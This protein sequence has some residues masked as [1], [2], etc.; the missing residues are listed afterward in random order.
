M[1]NIQQTFFISNRVS[2][3]I[4][5]YNYAEYVL[6]A[7]KSALDQK[8]KDLEVIVVDDG[9]T[10]NTEKILRPYKDRIKYLFQEN[11]GLSAAR[12]TGIK[13][14]T[15]EFIL[16]LDADDIIGPGVI[17]SHLNYLKRNPDIYITVCE[18]RVFDHTTAEGYPVPISD[19][20]KLFHENLGVHLCYFN[21]AP[22]HAFFSKRKAIIQT[23]WFDSQ[24]KACEDY[25]FLLRAAVKGFLPHYNPI[26]CVYYR[27]HSESM[28]ANLSNQYLHDAIIHKRLSELFD[29]YPEFPFGQRLEGLLAFSSGVLLTVSR[30]YDLHIEDGHELKDLAMKQ[31]DAAKEIARIDKTKWNILTKLFYFR[32]LSFL[33]HPCFRE[34]EFKASVTQSLHEILLALNASTSKPHLVADALKSALTGSPRAIW[35][36]RELA[37]RSLK[38]L[39]D[40]AFDFYFHHSK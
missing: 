17:A 9:S 26:G 38:Y 6:I 28:S 21:I 25:D 22:P 32:M 37:R 2:V 24:L 13:N 19:R 12:N 23:G 40:S 18:K 31:I 39:R 15:G 27:R 1:S 14:S 16:F 3:I 29:Q 5:T 8:I 10:D 30:L 33:N 36:R 4:T 11:S 34:S 35:E 7:I 20:W